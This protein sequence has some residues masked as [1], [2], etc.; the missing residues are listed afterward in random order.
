MTRK[1][2]QTKSKF[3]FILTLML[4][5]LICFSLFFVTACSSDETSSKKDTSYSYTETDDGVIKNASFAYGTVGTSLK[6]FPKTSLTGW[7]LSSDTSVSS[8]SGVI[9]V[10]DAGWK[11]LMNAL[12]G[13]SSIL[14]YAKRR[15]KHEFT[16]DDVKAAIKAENETDENPTS[17]EIKEYIVKNYF[18]SEVSPV[19]SNP[20]THNGAKDTKVYMLNSYKAGNNS[21]VGGVR[22]LTSS[23]EVTLNKGEYAKISVWI[24]TENLNMNIH[25]EDFGANIRINNSFNG[26]SQAVFGINNI[27]ADVWTEYTF[28]VKADEVYETK[29]TLVLGLGYGDMS[30]EG[31]V[32]FDDITVE[33]LEKLPDG[34]TINNTNLEYNAD[35]ENQNLIAA[36]G[37]SADSNILYVMSVDISDLTGYTTTEPF[38]PALCGYTTSNDSTA[39]GDRYDPEPEHKSEATE[40]SNLDA[41]YGISSGLKVTL[42]D[43]SY[44]V[45]S[46]P[47]T[48]EREKY[49]AVTFFIKNELSKF[50]ATTITVDVYDVWNAVTEKRAAVAT[51]SDVNDEWSKCTILV[52]NNFDAD[53]T[54]YSQHDTRKFYIQIVIGPTDV[55]T[56]N[57]TDYANGTVYITCAIVATGVTY[58]YAESDKN[59]EH[60]SANYDY[61]Q[62]FSNT[63]NATQ[64]LYAGMDNDTITDGS[65]NESYSFTYA[66]SEI[67]TILTSAATPKNYQGIS[68]NHY[69]INEESSNYEINKNENAGLIN[70]KYLD[71]YTYTN[72]K[73]ALKYNSADGNIQPLMIYNNAADSYGFIGTKNT[74]A[75]SAYAKVSVKVRVYGDAVA[76][77]YLVDVSN[78]VKQVMT[79]DDF[80]VNFA[81]GI[82]SKDKGTEIIGADKKFEIKVT[83]DMMND[84]GWL[85]VSFYIA[86]GASAKNFRVEV[87][88]GSRDGSNKSQGYVF[89]NDISVST[90]GAFSEASR[91]QDAFD[92]TGNPL[93][94]ADLSESIM[95]QRELTDTEKKYNSEYSDNTIS[96]NPTY[97]WAKN[98]SMIYA[99]YNT[100]DPVEVDPYEAEDDDDTTEDDGVETDPATFWLSFSS[101]LLGVA[102]IL[103]IAMLFIKNIRRRRKANKSDAKSHYKVTSRVSK[104]KSASKTKK[105]K[106]TEES[107]VD[108]EITADDKTAE[109]PVEEQTLDSYVYGEVEDFGENGSDEQ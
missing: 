59:K 104:K 90:S 77:V 6:N 67:G 57:K 82:N 100:I 48:V 62:L 109:N 73:S 26:T 76:Y 106:I 21:G 47:F 23:T 40:V 49:A 35:D 51:F 98:D 15:E 72:I 14:D 19:F 84:D 96:Y 108:E 68:Y 52:K 63:A 4:I 27:I 1:T 66:A 78:T 5:G 10:T 86:T 29:F 18:L 25:D 83:S 85:T 17:D 11:E 64:A 87:W 94:S 80:K 24:K 93:Y 89:F 3:K 36:A 44:V 75:A 22:K 74:V 88:N 9:D 13:D 102:L 70:S 81:D 46:N 91:W 103:A 39:K 37:V 50:S 43:A 53:N 8:K 55:K 2:Y 105:A 32:Y 28:Y 56:Q 95:Y 34:M 45:K 99:V 7:T 71:N 58:Q 33:H 12:Y 97:V 79:F 101:I 60:E 61:Y 38:P 92:T 54:N 20:G 16:I 65:T 41:P 107:P 30:V 31:T 42:N 69:Y